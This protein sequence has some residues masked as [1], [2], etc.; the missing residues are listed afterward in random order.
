MTRALII[1]ASIV[2][3]G[4]IVAFGMRYEHVEA[5]RGY[6]RLDRWGLTRPCVVWNAELHVFS[7]YKSAEERIA[8]IERLMGA[9]LC[10]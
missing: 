5:L 9:P 7:D 4:V 6:L 8:H 10:Y 1:G 2:L 3:A